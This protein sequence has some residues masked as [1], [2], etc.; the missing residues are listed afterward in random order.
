MY[1]SGFVTVIGRPNVGKSTL[2]NQIIGE[3]I[4]IISDKPQTTRNKIQL[5]YTEED[6]QIVFLDTPG[7][8]TP[9]NILGEYM[10]KVSKST[11]DEVDVVTF[12]VD[13]SMEIGKQDKGIIEQ[14]KD[15]KTPII[16]LI[17]KIDQLTKEE[18]D[19]LINKYEAMNMF[20]DIIPI[21]AIQNKNVDLYI[22]ALKKLLPE[23]PQYYPD[24]M[25]TDQPERMII[26]EIVREKALNNLEEE[27]PH[28][29]YVEVQEIKEREG[30][31]LL[32]VYVNLYCEK[33]SHK[34]MIIGKNGKMLKKI[35]TEARSDIEKLMDTKVNL[36][37]WVKVEKNW[38][39]KVDKVKYFGYKLS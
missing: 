25:I 26:A 6:V 13:N 12:M 10:L 3:K 9:K 31:N 33:E 28:G 15:V 23:G 11:L 30:K 27:I 5:V 4:S 22:N 29:I 37:I 36:K 34:G 2:L 39:D 24:D 35:G 38:R 21:S 7:I 20:E 19:Y 16:L 32:D 1:K 8:Q 17:N 18:I 14:L